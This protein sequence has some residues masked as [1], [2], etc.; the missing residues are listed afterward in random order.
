MSDGKNIL[1]DS[2]NPKLPDEPCTPDCRDCQEAGL[3]LDADANPN[4]EFGIS[5]LEWQ[6]VE[7]DSLA[8]V[9]SDKSA[10]KDCPYPFGCR[11]RNKDCLYKLDV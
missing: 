7:E 9:E 8:L 4:N 6:L 5:L 11:I 2:W 10:C 1:D 3:C